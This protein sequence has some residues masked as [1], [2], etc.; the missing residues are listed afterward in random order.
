MPNEVLRL[1]VPAVCPTCEVTGPISLKNT[2]K[3]GEGQEVSLL[4]YCETC[5][6]EWPVVMNADNVISDRRI[7]HV[8]RRRF[9][10]R[11]RRKRN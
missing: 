5:Q 9:S 11:D 3:E 4:W 6:A 8:D 2:R 7:G 10:R 1:R